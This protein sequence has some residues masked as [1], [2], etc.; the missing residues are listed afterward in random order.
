MQELLEHENEQVRWLAEARISVKST[1]TETR[2]ERY[3]WLGANGR[4]LPVYL[5]WF[6][7]HTGRWTASDGTQFQN[8]EKVSDDNPKKGM[9]KKSLCAIP[10]R[11]VVAADSGAIEARGTAWLAGHTE[12]IEGFKLNRDVYSDF[13]SIVYGRPIDRKKR[14]ED[15]VP[16][17]LGKVCVLGLGYGLGWSKLS[18]T[19]LAGAMGGPPV[20]LTEKDAD[21]MGVDVDA[22]L[23]DKRKATEITKMI[24]RLPLEQLVVHCACADKLV[25]T[26]RKANKPIKDLWKLM[27]SVLDVMNEAG[28]TEQFTFGP[29]E[30]LTIVRHGIIMPNGLQLRYPGL[31]KRQRPVEEDG[32]VRFN[33]TYE[34][35]HGKRGHTYGGAMLENVIQALA[36]IVISDQMLSLK[37]KYG[38][39]PVLLTHDE[40]AVIVEED[41]AAIAEY[42]LVEEMKVTPTWAKGWPLNAEGGH[43]Q[44]Y[45]EA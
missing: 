9:I 30:C 16:G 23:S 33:W 15:K 35:A 24:S 13:A 26:W 1:Q 34:G 32:W 42:R 29:N 11:K 18:T 41:Q 7:A 10:G 17:F 8:L 38:Y 25:Q 44:S 4:P 20:T 36:R 21:T 3:L 31:Q 43:G 45:G 27:E 37:A 12:L 28:D 2:G 6:G 22:F 40:E 14:K 39:E 5:K 19:L